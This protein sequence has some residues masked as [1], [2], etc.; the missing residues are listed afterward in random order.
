MSLYVFGTTAYLTGFS[1]NELLFDTALF[2]LYGVAL[3]AV[4]VPL[5]VTALAYG[6][7]PLYSTAIAVG[8]SLVAAGL[9]VVLSRRCGPRWHDRLRAK[10]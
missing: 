2:A 1:A 3:A 10:S 6:E 4:A 8:L 9:G 7:A 5:L